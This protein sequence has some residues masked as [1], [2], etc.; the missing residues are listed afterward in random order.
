VDNPEQRERVPGRART[1]EVHEQYA[2]QQIEAASQA[3]PHRVTPPTRPRTRPARVTIPASAK[4]TPSIMI[5]ASVSIVPTAV[6]YQQRL[7]G[8]YQTCHQ[9]DAADY[10]AKRIFIC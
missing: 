1:A 8:G 10:Q 7:C 3:T 6:V 9:V 4:P 2:E 5:D